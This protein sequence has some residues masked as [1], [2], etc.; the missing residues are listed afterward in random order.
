MSV[1]ERWPQHG[2]DVERGGPVGERVQPR[3]LDHHAL[4]W[5]AAERHF[6][7]DAGLDP[8]DQRLGN[9]IG[10]GAPRRQGQGDLREGHGTLDRDRR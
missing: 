8:L 5:A 4:A 6:H 10:E 9:A 3:E 1:E 7:L 2:S